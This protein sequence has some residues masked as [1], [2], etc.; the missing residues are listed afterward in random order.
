[1]DFFAKL[2]HDRTFFADTLIQILVVSFIAY[3][4]VFIYSI[5][6]AKQKKIELHRRVQTILWA[7]LAV[8]VVIFEISVRIAGGADQIFQKS[9]LKGTLL[10]EASFY[11]HFWIA[12]STFLFWSWLLFVSRR[13]AGTELPGKFSRIHRIGG[14]I[15]FVGLI[16]TTVTCIEL[17]I[18]GK[19]L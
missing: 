13:K 6:L 19:I 12:T 14:Y 4:P 15:V 1:M 10:L 11:I 18:V 3:M 17:F 16:L 9:S 2:F 5:K 7:V 8:I